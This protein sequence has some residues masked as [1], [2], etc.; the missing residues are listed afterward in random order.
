[1]HGIVRLIL[2]QSRE[3]QANQCKEHLKSLLV[4]YPNIEVLSG[5]RNIEIRPISV[6]KGN[7]ARILIKRYYDS[8]KKSKNHSEDSNSLS[9]LATKDSSPAGLEE[10]TAMSYE[11]KNPLPVDLDFIL[12][13]G[14]DRTDEDMFNIL[15]NIDPLCEV[16]CCHVGPPNKNTYA[17]WRIPS[18]MEMNRLLVKLSEIEVEKRRA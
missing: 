1:M 5:K 4:T 10:L 15:E 3:F 2:T 13:A 8:S 16:Y 17:K 7:I 11:M 14:D 18:P 9:G 6:S 12:C